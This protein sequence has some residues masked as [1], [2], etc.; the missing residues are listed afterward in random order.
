MGRNAQ[1]YWA[2]LEPIWE[3]VSIYDRVEVF[4]SQ[5][6]LAPNASRTLFAAHWCQSEVRNGGLHQFF[7]NST[8]VLAPEAIVA[9]EA[10]GMPKVA[11]VL[12][13]AVAWFGPIY[14]RERDAREAL[15]DTYENENPEQ[16]N[17]FERLDDQFFELIDEENGGFRKAADGYAKGI[18]G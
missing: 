15:L 2:L 5:F 6:N 8:G 3:K 11:A 10:L 7:T 18:G 14:P 1:G 4:E 9:Y 16:W 12:R 13:A 17:P